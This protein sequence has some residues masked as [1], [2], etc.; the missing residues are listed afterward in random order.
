MRFCP[1]CG[2]RF[3]SPAQ[4]CT[5]DGATLVVEGPSTDPYVGTKI[6]GHFR[7][8]RVIGTGGMGTV[9]EAIDEGIGRRVAV[10]ILHKDL[11][12]NRDVAARFQREAQIASQLDHPNL[13]RLILFGQL[14]DGNLYLVLE[15]LNGPTFAKVLEEQAPLATARAVKIV[16]QI[17]DAIGY[18]H[19]KGIVHRDLKPENVILV[20]RD[21]DSE[22]PKV[23]DFGIAKS[24]V[25]NNTMMTGTGLIFGTA[26]YISPEGAQGEAVDRRSDVYSLGVIAFQALTGK[27]PF[28]APEPMQ[29]LLKHIHNAVPKM[30]KMLPAGVTVPDEIESVV[31][32]A[33]SKNPEGRYDD[34]AAF[35][36]ALREALARSDR[37]ATHKGV[38]PTINVAALAPPAS[39]SAASAS[40]TQSRS[41]A[42]PP[43]ASVKTMVGSA[44]LVN[45]NDGGA[46]LAFA[47]TTRS[48]DPA[49]ER[50]RA[51]AAALISSSGNARTQSE[52]AQQQPAKK[53]A[54][55]VEMGAIAMPV[56]HQPSAT[57]SPSPAKTVAVMPE[58]SAASTHG[59]YGASSVGAPV[60]SQYGANR[61]AVAND[62]GDEDE[63]NIAG[64][65]KMRERSQTGRTIAIVLV[66]V[67][68]TLGIGLASMWGMGMF[69]SQRRARLVANM[70]HDAETALAADRLMHSSD[71]NVEDL[72][73][74]ILRLSPGNARAQQLRQAAAMRLRN[75]AVELRNDTRVEQGLPLLRS[76]L[77][78]TPNNSELTELIALFEREIRERSTAQT[79]SADAG[80]VQ[81]PTTPSVVRPTQPNS[82]RVP[83]TGNT[84]NT[85]N[86]GSTGNTGSSSNSGTSSGGVTFTPGRDPNLDP[87]RHNGSVNTGN[88]ATTGSTE[89]T[90]SSVTTGSPRNTGSTGNTEPSRDTS[91]T[92]NSGTNADPG[93]EQGTEF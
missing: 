16:A 14:P 75:R 42:P 58:L 92:G 64:L 60:A 70:L 3:E 93:N 17:S 89:T 74:T 56:Q 84:G 68:V 23:L 37:S 5:R 71:Q 32:R 65:P 47:T 87:E 15:Y 21:E 30:S 1:R 6:L 86:L 55:R 38:T 2:S 59:A 39:E 49:L 13:V 77:L 54:P 28:D 67:I 26:R 83:R 85:S 73:S 41:V 80:V 57:R 19:R 8:D 7:V 18:V 11:M 45:A 27:T 79:P 4:F 63:F 25:D 10:K 78:L 90:G 76:A 36:K 9:Y 20:E 50:A 91:S 53:V 44:P 81:R 48:D 52:A 22:F 34:G 72:T 62:L 40:A 46:V 61:P 33:L 24:L 66:T 88:T 51:E 82:G 69:P 29:L 43:V 35:A 31:Q 12:T